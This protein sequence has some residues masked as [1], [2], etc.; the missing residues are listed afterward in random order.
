MNV[1]WYV[2]RG[3]GAVSLLLLTAVLV[4]GVLSRMGWRTARWPRFLTTALHRNL[5]LL[6]LLFLGL[7]IVTAV[8]DPYT[9]L[10]LGAALVPFSS[11]YRTFWLGLGVVAV[12]LLVAVVLTS[13]LRHL[14]G[15]RG[16]RLVHWL[17]YAC[18]PVAMIHG[19][20]TGS[21][22]LRTWMTV[23]DLASLAAVAGAIGLRLASP[24][25]SA[26]TAAAGRRI[27][28]VGDGR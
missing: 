26:T 25:A 2:T 19:L 13:L 27:L 8:V 22:T 3:A 1:L 9:S 11:Q 28:R 15:H 6:S 10:G 20:G 17:A 5:A 16:W 21:D 24:P 12:D 23:V 18:W 7:H 14:I 4:L